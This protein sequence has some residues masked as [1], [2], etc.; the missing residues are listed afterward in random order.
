[1][2][3]WD[4]DLQGSLNVGTASI[5]LFGSTTAQTVNLG[6]PSATMLQLVPTGGDLYI[7]DAE[8]NRIT[9]N[10]GV[11]VG[12]SS[13]G[14]I[15]VDGITDVSSS[16]L[17]RVNLKATT[18]SREINFTGNLSSFNKGIA[19]NAK[20]GVTMHQSVTTKNQE[21]VINTST[22][23]FRLDALQDLST[24]NQ[25]LTI[26]SDELNIDGTIHTGS[27]AV[28]LFPNSGLT[29]GLGGDDPTQP[30]LVT[31]QYDVRSSVLG[32]IFAN[33]LT[34]G[35][36]M[37][38]MGITVAGVTAVNSGGITNI[39]TLIT[40]VDG[41]KIS[42]ELRGSSFYA[43]AAQAD[44]GIGVSVHV[45]TT[46][47]SLYLDADID[48]DIDASQSPDNTLRIV[49]SKILTSKTILTLKASTGSL[50]PLGA[51]TLVAGSGIVIQ[52]NLTADSTG[53][54]FVIFSDYESAGD[55]TLTVNS[56]KAVTSFNSPITITAW[57]ISLFGS[58]TAGTDTITIHGAQADQTITLG[59]TPSNM[60]ITDT[61]LGHMT[62]NGD[63]TF[64]SS[65]SGNIV[66]SGI[67]EFNSNSFDHIRLVVKRPDRT[68]STLG[69]DSYFSKGMV[70]QAV[71]GVNMMASLSTKDFP[72]IISCGTGT[73]TVAPTKSLSSYY[74]PIV[75]TADDIDIG[76]NGGISA[77][78]SSIELYVT[79]NDRT[80]GLGATP[81]DYQ[82][83]DMEL[84]RLFSAAGLVVGNTN[85]GSIFVDGLTQ[86][87]TSQVGTISLLVTNPTRL[88]TFQN[89]S[90]EFQ[91]GIVV[92]SNGG[93]VFS[94][95]VNTFRST[96]KLR[97]SAGT[98]T[99]A[100]AKSL[101]TNGQV[102]EVVTND[103]DISG[104]VNTGVQMVNIQCATAGTTVG[105][106]S[107][108]QFTMLGS[109]LQFITA[110]GLQIGG[111]NCGNQEVSGITTANSN[112]ITS[113]MTLLAIRSSAKV[114][115]SVA[116]SS[117][118]SLAVKADDDIMVNTDISTTSSHLYLDGDAHNDVT[119]DRTITFA[120]D[121]TISSSVLMT[122]EVTEGKIEAQKAL[123]LRAG[124]GI[125]VLNDLILSDH[126]AALVIH[127]DYDASNYGT[128]TVEATKSII[129]NDGA[130]TLTAWDVDLAGS[131]NNGA[132][133]A[134]LL[135]ARLS[136]TIALGSTVMNMQITDDELGRWTCNG[137]LTVGSA[138]SGSITVDKI[139]SAN[140][141]SLGVVLNLIATKADQTVI[142][143]KTPS[144]FNKG[145]TIQ[146]MGGVILNT[147]VTTCD[148]KLQVNTG[149]G[150]LTVAWGILLSTTNQELVVTTDDLRL[151]GAILTGAAATSITCFSEGR[152]VSMGAFAQELAI[153]G[154]EVQRL[155]STGFVLGGPQ[156][157]SMLIYD[158]SKQNSDFISSVV[159]LLATRDDARVIFDGTS[160]TFSTLDVLADNGVIVKADL[161]T[162]VGAMYLNGDTD[163]SS[164]MDTNL[165]YFEQTRTITAK[166]M[167]TLTTTTGVIS[168][169]GSLTLLAGTGIVINGDFVG[170]IDGHA[171]VI[172]A[173]NEDPGDG[174]LTVAF[175]R[176]I[177]SN[178]APISI[179]SWDLDVKGSINAGTNT[180]N[181]L[182]LGSR[183]YASVVG[184]GF[185][186]T[187]YN[188]GSFMSSLN[189]YGSKLAQTI[190]IGSATKNLSLSDVEI[191]RM[192]AYAGL[193]VGSS[194][195]E[196]VTVSGVTDANSDTIGR[197][198]LIA[199]KDNC[200]VDFRDVA[201]TF[202]KGVTVQGVG[203][204]Y[205][206]ESVVTKNTGTI[207][208]TG[209]STL[210]VA[211]TKGISSTSQLL[212]VTSDD[213]DLSG[214][215]NTGTSSLTL[216]TFSVTTVGLGTTSQQYDIEAAE[217]QRITAT[218]VTIGSYFRNVTAVPHN[219]L[220]NY[221]ITVQGITQVNSNTITG[222][223]TLIASIDDAQ[224]QFSGAS[225]TFSALSAQADNGVIVS[226]D[227]T[228]VTGALYLNGDLEN[229]STSDM[230][231]SLAF[232]DL[233]TMTAA[234]VMTLEDS[235]GTMRSA[236]QLTLRSGDGIVLNTNSEMESSGGKLVL[237]ADLAPFGTGTVTITGSKVISSSNGSILI[238]T[239]DFD[240]S[241]GLT[242]GTAQMKVYTSGDNQQIG[243]GV[244]STYP[245]FIS[246]TELGHMTAGSLS[247]GSSTSGTIYVGGVTQTN[248]DSFNTLTLIATGLGQR[249]VS[250]EQADSQ[251]NKGIT[252]QAK[253]AG[254]E[255]KSNVDTFASDDAFD[256]GFN[257]LVTVHNGKLFNT[258]GQDIQITA[259]DLD[260]RQSGR[261]WA[262][263]S[264]FAGNTPQV[265][266]SQSTTGNRVEIR[267][268]NFGYIRSQLFVTFYDSSM[269]LIAQTGLASPY[270][271]FVTDTLIVT[272]LMADTTQISGSIY[273][274]VKRSA[275]KSDMVNIGKISDSIPRP[276]ITPSVEEIASSA[277]FLYI[278]GSNF[279]TNVTN[280]R[281]YVESIA[282][283]RQKTP[284]IYI[285]AVMPGSDSL[286]YERIS[287]SP[288]NFSSQ[289]LT[290]NLFYGFET[291]ITGF[292]DINVGPVTVTVCVN[293]IKSLVT[294]VTTLILKPAIMAT[295]TVRIARSVGLNRLEINGWRFAGVGSTSEPSVSVQLSLGFAGYTYAT[296][297]NGFVGDKFVPTGAIFRNTIYTLTSSLLVIDLPDSTMAASGLLYA[298]VTRKRGPSDPYPISVFTDAIP[299]P[300]VTLE[301]EERSVRASTILLRGMGFLSL[302]SEV[303]MYLY[304]QNSIDGAILG[305]VRSEKFGSTAFVIENI[306]GLQD[307]TTCACAGSYG[308]L[309][310][311]VT[312]RGV[313]SDI[314]VIATIIPA[315]IVT[316]TAIKIAVNV[317]GN[318]IPIMGSLFGIRPQNIVVELFATGVSFR[319][320]YAIVASGNEITVDVED[321]TSKA[322]GPVYAV[323]W[324]SG[325]PSN[326]VQIGNMVVALGQEPQ[327]ASSNLELCS[328]VTMLAIQGAN[329]G[330][331]AGDVRVYLTASQ[332]YLGAQLA[333][334]RTAPFTTESFVVDILGFTD[335]NY[336]PLSALVTVQT[337]RAVSQ[338]V[339]IVNK[340]SQDI[341]W[342]TAINNRLVSSAP[343]LLTYV[344]TFTLSSSDVVSIGKN[345][346]D[347]SFAASAPLLSNGVM[348]RRVL[349]NDNQ[350]VLPTGF[351]GDMALEE[352]DYTICVCHQYEGSTV[353][354]GI[355]TPG[356]CADKA[357][358]N[359]LNSKVNIFA[360]PRLGFA[361]TATPIQ[362]ISK[363]NPTFKIWGTGQR[364]FEVGDIV[365]ISENGCSSLP[366]S[367][368]FNTTSFLAVTD[369]S[370]DKSTGTPVPFA[371]FQLPSLNPLESLSSTLGRS[372]KVCFTTKESAMAVSN[373]I[374]LAQGITVIPPPVLP[375]S[376]RSWFQDNIYELDFSLPGG[377]S[378]NDIF[379]L[380]PQDCA[381]SYRR[382]VAELFPLSSG[383]KALL[384]TGA[385]ARA[386][387]IAQGKINELKPMVYKICYATKTSEG[388]AQGDFVMLD[389]TIEIKPPPTEA[390]TL[391]M[392]ETVPLGADIVVKWS[393]S[394]G[395]DSSK[396][397]TAG[398]WIG[399]YR[400]GSCLTK[401]S[402][403]TV[404]Q[405][406]CYLASRSLAVNT[407][408]GE[409]AFTYEEYKSSG[410]FETRYFRGDTFNGQGIMCRGLKQVRGTFL[411]CVLEA[412]VTS[413]TSTFV[414]PDEATISQGPGLEPSKLEAT[415]ENGEES[416]AVES[417][418]FSV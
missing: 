418:G 170:T 314:R 383:V 247:I 34:L 307:P 136:Q 193:T 201:S 222:V 171:L 342:G 295:S 329:L 238:T 347:C 251:F 39:L 143:D 94:A 64:G 225:S 169:Y 306:V 74:Q 100:A 184:L 140:T 279:G 62:A 211:T 180:N 254:L 38:S 36:A 405:H 79:T 82:L 183:T 133:Q 77:G 176:S 257:L 299:T 365:F 174:T 328:S 375:A 244:I 404:N 109:E 249:M 298:I 317:G 138:Y 137:G 209:T 266:I 290:A 102:L 243:I 310:G 58:L 156:C 57:D 387:A 72:L 327:I 187:T 379:V 219:T 393:A 161:V 316:S 32:N 321:D 335:I 250:F 146:G 189:I 288:N 104:A 213:L 289:Q 353:M 46:V 212:T 21:T 338:V 83:T 172:N 345:Q 107:T 242:S 119:G 8:L 275:I 354:G 124:M 230:K 399:L 63:L 148:S 357:F 350:I 205:V 246:D 368:S 87:G 277:P 150:S 7:S 18:A 155:S 116:S 78:A 86:G 175:G 407:A 132:A 117:F 296:E 61:E 303:R 25:R 179:T 214:S 228:A 340:G 236:S 199:L 397:T 239:T 390:P 359:M 384:Q 259:A 50:I 381:N 358:F 4:L 270:P 313:K 196:H 389:S 52:D 374:V 369:P 301:L 343:S 120:A 271:L 194:I 164:S 234:T 55:G 207:I 54:P 41:E 89:T 115:F 391:E 409:V 356:S 80:I 99:V 182:F 96:T 373:F 351:L 145:L 9:G 360:R 12:G 382:N 167:M 168:K 154:G 265:L 92:D 44:H 98:I 245:M 88:V 81:R 90:S 302:S 195:S 362:A 260:L 258:N 363:T 337:V 235:T 371:V 304:G 361:A 414:D 402:T 403:N 128:F 287:V 108:Q 105:I 273:A 203:G 17:G 35:Q 71:G 188:V 322:S 395:L 267:G 392:P 130:L 320:T 122:L 334:V 252:V 263:A 323:V 166:A 192:T 149:T 367:N 376:Q 346:Q 185:M 186:T 2:T 223:V 410:D 312:V 283:R 40:S 43:L 294:T 217:V 42:F 240:L 226:V 22:S 344:A 324:R 315:A 272:D 284:N 125:V 237:N 308:A 349:T 264:P 417:T 6:Q 157:G 33:G 3:V 210:T 276:V 11:T 126:Y 93:I 400:K 216:E 204:I 23:G 326:S 215:I 333:A 412:A 255:F 66:I 190:G 65:S 394:N 19:V 241:G 134:S 191:G 60:Q 256:V 49:D 73:L 28:L 229:S 118:H 386:Y 231:Y 15:N 53:F 20:G 385:M 408:S 112:G 101:S 416:W 144:T 27:G 76:A 280:V 26:L 366:T 198:T 5:T 159:T 286:M 297:A 401:G 293:S 181:T 372:L 173:D 221:S 103:V 13:N 396:V 59:S 325:G 85:S 153:S 1:M 114:T 131:M 121:R 355:L 31:S 262:K 84:G 233:R 75:I 227:L 370:A 232:T 253:G 10:G 51:L 135:G 341:V 278:T 348:V 378:E 268:S 45:T 24:T 127:S 113:W 305:D 364:Y 224:I 300:T 160:S 37:V 406:K 331:A 162:T 47:N 56:M 95:N 398:T 178:N 285:S 274:R 309:S 281:V 415:F 202:N 330:S 220:R 152:T 129:T 106:G 48:A 388:D 197:L 111:D 218:G 413:A 319:H 352:G 110:T 380:E 318:R 29:I 141:D 147:D 200:Y 411:Q 69:L 292:Q 70:W 261:F 30:P 208:F 151:D 163:N 68:I 165:F 97:T 311:I 282:N 336:G 139:S 377:S 206:R 269:N 16:N 158:I 91:K 14:N 339:A 177:S 332:G 123:T 248:S 291:Y 142:F 67:Q